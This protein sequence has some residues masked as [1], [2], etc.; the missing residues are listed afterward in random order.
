MIA[1]FHTNAS[2]WI[3]EAGKYTVKIGASS[4]DIKSSTSF[5][6]WKELVV[7]KVYKALTPQVSIN[8]LKK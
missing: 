1:S 5:D 2:S 4:L 3:A 7:E 6:L 8:E